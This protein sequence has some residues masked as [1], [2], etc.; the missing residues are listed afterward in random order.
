MVGGKRLFQHEAAALVGR[1]DDD[2]PI[3]RPQRNVPPDERADGVRLLRLVMG[4]KEM[5]VLRRNG[6][7]REDLGR[8]QPATHP[9]RLHGQ[10]ACRHD[11]LHVPGL[12]AHVAEDARRL[13]GIQRRFPRKED[14]RDAARML[15]CRADALRRLPR[16]GGK[17]R[18]KDVDPLE[19]FRDR[20]GQEGEIAALVQQTVLRKK[21]GVLF[22]EQGKVGELCA[23]RPLRRLCARAQLRRVHAGGGKLGER[24][25]HRLRRARR[26]AGELPFA[27]GKNGGDRHDG[28]LFGEYAALSR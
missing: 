6:R 22:R 1:E 10:G 14:A 7:L 11:R 16:K 4:G 27:P 12:F 23:Q 26:E 20:L 18:K 3:A 15:S 17:R 5:D 13:V 2:V 19:L 21:G 28:A 8:K 25:V 9:L 24:L